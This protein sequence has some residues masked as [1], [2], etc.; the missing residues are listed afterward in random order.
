MTDANPATALGLHS[1]LQ[2]LL[3]REAVTVT[4]ETPLRSA[5]RVMDEARVGSLVIVDPEG[6][7][8]IGI[9]TLRD[10]LHRVAVRDL[11]LDLSI[12]TVM[13]GGKLVTLNRRA[14]LYQA[15]LT[16]ARHGLRHVIV[17]DGE[18]QLAGIVSQND[19]YR[20][21]RGGDQS[22]SSNIRNASD[23]PA[24][25]AVAAE[26][27]R[28]TMQM[29]AEGRNAEAITQ[30]ISTLNDHLTVRIIELTAAEFTLPRVPW[31]WLA[32]GS[33]GRFEQTFSTDQDNG[34]IFAAPDDGAAEDNGDVESLRQ[35]F[36][37][38][39]QEVNRRLDACGFTL[40]KGGIM[41]GNPLWCLSLAEWR[42][43]FS[44][45]LHAASPQALLNA[46][47][48]FDFRALYGEE[49][50][51]EELN[52]WLFART[53]REPLFLRFMAE[54]AI[55]VEPPLGLIRD[56]VFDRNEKFPHTIDLKAYG[57]RLFV[58][59]AR[60]FALA[61]GIAHTGTV[62]RLRQVAEPMGFS[63]DDL[64]AIIDGFYYIQLQRLRH[65]YHDGAA[66]NAEAANRIDPDRLNELGRHILKEAF[67]QARK[68]QQRL[69][70]D[71]RL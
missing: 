25:V 65:Q 21:L 66:D 38:F 4:A 16:M 27:R 68:L 29:L 3:S 50:L 17:V 32:F 31:C 63:H 42:G 13:S 59:A 36:L 9:F 41:A 23:L 12:A 70:W 26:I 30:Q 55:Q 15:A 43:K 20:L 53:V 61:H 28:L 64:S 62:E 57:S 6:R 48:F 69:R 7:R 52:A 35:A 5:L 39:A 33:E 67:K 54:N 19:I 24:L 56:F 46:T 18:G 58:D 10:V 8:P 44:G 47:I 2:A 34:L 45:W 11:D 71:Y 14:T 1:E 60:I 49:S 22:V 40:C 51:A 37:P